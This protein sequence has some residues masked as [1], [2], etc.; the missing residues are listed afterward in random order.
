[1]RAGVVLAWLA[2]AIGMIAAASALLV[3]TSYRVQWFSLAA[4]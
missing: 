4:A 3:G 1:M 2:F